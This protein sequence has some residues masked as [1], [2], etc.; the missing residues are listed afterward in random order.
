M[1]LND[2]QQLQDARKVAEY[3]EW[4]FYKDFVETVFDQYIDIDK[5]EN[6]TDLKVA[7]KLRRIKDN[8]LFNN[9]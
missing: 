3:E 4:R 1:D 5:L 9:Q 2:H 6:E 7:Q 8:I